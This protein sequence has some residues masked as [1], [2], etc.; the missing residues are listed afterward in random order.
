MLLWLTE[1]MNGITFETW[2]EHWKA[3]KDCPGDVEAVVR[4]WRNEKPPHAV[5][6]REFPVPGWRKN[7]LV[8]RGEQVLE[9]Q[10]LQRTGTIPRAVDVEDSSRDSAVFALFS[11]FAAA[12]RRGSTR[13]Q[14]IADALGIL[15][16]GRSYHPLAIEVKVSD[17]NCWRAVVQNLQQ[18]QFFRYSGI[19][20]RT[21]LSRFGA[22][23]LP[24]ST[25]LGGVWGLVVAPRRYWAK[26]RS[27]FAEAQRLLLRL[28]EK[29][30][31]KRTLTEARVLL[32]AMD[33]GEGRVR[34]VG[35][36][37]YR[38]AP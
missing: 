7:S 29:A 20:F 8:L 13:G 33:E 4:Q 12:K 32:G 2:S 34:L 22:D 6:G 23:F 11:N 3:L 10:L 30:N 25:R 37:L 17:G 26:P 38:N 35:G 14:I 27:Y 16:V 9:D 24:P 36:H 15:R 1:S 21:T 19:P 5:L 28:S 18:V 31:G